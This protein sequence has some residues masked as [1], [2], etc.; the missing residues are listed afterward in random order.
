AKA[1]APQPKAA[2]AKT[3]PAQ[4]AKQDGKWNQPSNGQAKKPAKSGKGGSGL[5]WMPADRLE[6]EIERLSKDLKAFDDELAKEEVYRDAALFKK[7]MAQRDASHAELERFEE[8]WLRR[9]E[10]A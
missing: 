3:A 2:P 5:S 10:D 8:E 1:S 4:P 7:T 6:K 9:A